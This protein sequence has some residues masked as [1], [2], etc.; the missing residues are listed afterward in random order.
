M[1]ILIIHDPCPENPAKDEIDTQ[2]QV[3]QVS[4]ALQSLGH[5]TGS[6]DFSL[7]LLQMKSRINRSKP[8]YIFNLVE[9][10]EGSRLIHFAPALFETMGIPFSGG[11]SQGMM[12]SS[13]KL[14]AK[15]I[16]RYAGVPTP[17]WVESGAL[18]ECPALIG[19]PVIIKPADEEASV[20]ICDAS[21]GVFHSQKAL[22]EALRSPI[23]NRL[24]A[25]RFIQGREFNISVLPINGIPRVLPVA[26]MLFVDYPLDKPKIVGYEAKWHEDSFA[27]SH[28]QRTFTFPPADESLLQQLKEISLACWKLFGAKGYARIDFRVDESGQPY[29][30]E[31]NLNPCVTKDSGFTA[32]AHAAGFDYMQM[33]S[34]LVTGDGDGYVGV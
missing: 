11:G 27:Y 4:E 19:V 32:A 6:L 33:I 22:G 16:M 12:M 7:D 29:V 3:L 21:V 28:T 26:E 17:A 25:E 24:F 18:S 2:L 8:D 10:L 5:C 30:L 23:K 9:T 15:K 31:L 13:D 20:G 1:D 34:L 14:L